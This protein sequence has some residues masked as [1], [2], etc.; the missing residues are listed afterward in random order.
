MARQSRNVQ[1]MRTTRAAFSGLFLTTLFVSGGLGACTGDDPIAG[2]PAADASTPPIGTVTPDG[3]VPPTGDGAV[4]DAAPNDTISGAVRDHRGLPL[5]QAAVTLTD[6]AGKVATLT[7]GA[8]GK[9]SALAIKAPYDAIVQRQGSLVRHVFL[10]VGTG[11]PVFRT[12]GEFAVTEVT[13]PITLTLNP[14]QTAGVV[15]VGGSDLASVSKLD[16]ANA[17]FFA[18]PTTTSF[19]MT[20]AGVVIPAAGARPTAFGEVAVTADTAAAALFTAT[21]PLTTIPATGGVAVAST[22]VR[23]PTFKVPHRALK[24]DFG[25]RAIAIA[26]TTASDDP[27]ANFG[28]FSTLGI[29]KKYAVEALGAAD[30]FAIAGRGRFAT[31][32]L[33]F[34]RRAGLAENALNVVVELAPAATIT[35][36][37]DAA[38]GFPRK[39]P[40]TFTASSPTTFQRLHAVRVSPKVSG[41]AGASYIVY[42]ASTSATLPGE[43]LAA[44]TAYVTEVFSFG[45]YTTID[46]FL[47]NTNPLPLEVLEIAGLF[48][49]G[50]AVRASQDGGD[51]FLAITSGREFTTGL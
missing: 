3:S 46:A 32:P 39:G 37:I 47:G 31:R 38:T 5:A 45:P 22:L 44:S 40:I 23:P 36:P 51:T 13:R 11:A 30:A 33:T 26:Q 9:F 1:N 34:G 28:D 19:P 29:G 10:G 18:L 20:V 35:A 12:Y 48:A 49:E 42:G 2:T 7:T 6:A 14:A 16:L 27:R 17:S 41:T 8:D 4:P 24:L 25:S 15:L 50:V 43:G 21:M